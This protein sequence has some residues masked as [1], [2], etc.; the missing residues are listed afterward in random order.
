MIRICKNI[1]IFFFLALFAL[2]KNAVAQN[3]KTIQNFWQW[4]GQ[5]EKR[6]RNFQQSP[7]AHLNEILK[8]IKKIQDGLAIELEPPKN[9]IINLTISAN[10]D[11]SLFSIVKKIVQSTPPLS[12]WH[13]FA[14]R[15]RMDASTVKGMKM[16]TADFELDPEKIKFYPL[17]DGDALDVI[18]Y[19]KGVNESNYNQVA[20]GVFILLDNILGEYD[21][22]MKVRHYDIKELPFLRTEL[23]KLTPLLELAKYVDGR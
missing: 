13:V 22:A 23:E 1:S 10:G 16:K 12:G 15:Q 8:E 17:P 11:T 4:F 7:E 20:Y 2:P 19:V 21:A 5:N 18:L 9:G 14:F 6:F 3:Q